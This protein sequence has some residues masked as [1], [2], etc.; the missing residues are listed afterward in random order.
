MKKLSIILLSALSL[1]AFAQQKKVAVYV[2]GEQS[3]I[4]R[5][6]G[7]E[8]V[9]AFAKSSKY[10]AVERTT[11]FL[12]ELGNEHSYQQ[13]G[14]VSDREIAR[15]GVQFGVDY[16]CLAD[17]LEAFGEKYIYARLIDVETA[18][19]V[20]SHKVTGEITSMGACVKMAE[21]IANNLSKGSFTEQAAEEKA[22]AEKEEQ[23]QQKREREEQEELKRQQQAEQQARQ[24]Q[25]LQ[26]SVVNLSNAIIDAVES[27]KSYTLV[28]NNYQKHPYKILVEGN[29]LGVVQPYKSESFK[30][31]VD[32]YGQFKAVQTSGYLF[33]PTVLTGQIPRQKAT[34]TYTMHLKTN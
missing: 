14:A 21:E 23:E 5:I 32:V 24:Q 11:N 13:S 3:S 17:M 20:N 7:A 22:K 6:L 8:L 2:T 34:A 19:V 15:L 31:P 29:L 27:S 9:E 33:S 12:E 18:E 28:V 25:Q 26:Q 16:V 1:T 10:T 4:S 30:V